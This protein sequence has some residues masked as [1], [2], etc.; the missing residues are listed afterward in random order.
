M[1]P[2]DT[3]YPVRLGFTPDALAIPDPNHP[4]L[5]R[6]GPRTSAPYGGDSVEVH[7]CPATDCLADGSTRPDLERGFA[8]RQVASAMTSLENARNEARRKQIYLERIVQPHRPDEALEPRRARAII[9]IFIAG[10][11]AWA[12][13]SMLVAGVREHKD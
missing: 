10:L 13:M 6:A 9:S 5:R 12:V 7:V 4:G 8:D 2:T 1:A 11:V 3:S